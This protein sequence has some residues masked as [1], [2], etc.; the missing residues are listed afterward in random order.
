MFG[1][2]L[3]G[4]RPGRPAA[5]RQALAILLLAAWSLAAIPD[6]SFAQGAATLVDEARKAAREDR[7]EEAA[8]LFERALQA[9]PDLRSS[10]LREYADQLTYSRRPAEAVPL[11]R[12]VLARGSLPAEEIRRAER[13]LALALL[14]SGA[15]SEAVSVWEAINR[16][17]PDDLDARK[18]FR[19]ALISAAREAARADQNARSAEF[20]E[21]AIR[22]D[23]ARRSE[24]L[25]EYADQLTFSGRARD[26]VPLFDEV[27]AAPGLSAAR[28]NEAVRGRA[29]AYLFAGDYDRAAAAW[30]EIAS[31][32]PND[33]DA[34]RNLSSAIF[35]LAREAAK[36]NRNRRSA[37]LYEQLIELD[38]GRRA[39][40]L[41]E[42]ADQL[43]FSGQAA[44]A[45]PLFEEV[46]ASKTLSE[47]DKTAAA[48]G[49]AVA[50]LF[51]GQHQRARTAWETIL[52]ANP[53]DRDAAKNLR[54]A[55]IGLA[56]EAARRDQNARSASLFAEAIALD[57][58]RRRDILQEYA[59]QLTY[60]GQAAKAV[61]LFDEILRDNQLNADARKRA[62]RGRA[63]ALLF[64]EDFTRAMAAWREILKD[65]PRDTD[66]RK[67]LFDATVGAAR[68][69]A[70]S[71]QNSRSAT[72]FEHA[73]ATAPHR[74]LEILREYAD[75][76][77][78][79]E[80]AAQ[81]V[82]LYQE[83]LDQARLDPAGRRQASLGLALAQSWSGDLTGA[84][85]T[86]D[87][88]LREQPQDVEARLGRGRVLSW[89][90][91]HDESLREYEFV[92]ALDPGSREGIR[93]AARE[94]SY[95]GRHRSALA[96]LEPLLSGQLSPA[97]AEALNVAARARYWMGRPDAAAQMANLILQWDPR[98]RDAAALLVEIRRSQQPETAIQASVSEQN[99]GLSIR[100]GSV[101][102]S[103]TLNE[104]LTTLG[105][106]GRLWDFVPRAGPSVTLRALGLAG[107]HRFTDALEINSQV[108][109]NELTSAHVEHVRV[110]HDTWITFWPNDYLRFDLGANRNYFD[111][112]RSL[113]RDIV[114][115]TFGLSVDVTP[116]QNTRL[117]S[118]ASYGLISDGN[119]RL[120]GQLEAERRIWNRPNLFVGAKLTG[121]DFARQVDNG[122]FNPDWLVAA[123][124]MLRLQFTLNGRLDV[125]L[126]GS[127]G[128][129]RSPDGQ[130]PIYSGA[131]QLSYRPTDQLNLSA[132]VSYQESSSVG[133][134]GG[135]RRATV[136]GSL[137]Y[138]W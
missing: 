130:K 40:V 67:N 44:K 14:W 94:E 128:S 15:G 52:R 49:L 51:S 81:A 138:R 58:H 28:R 85:V 98:N 19:E 108:F 27:L 29:L 25:R 91:R 11:Y 96:R 112:V 1:I 95:L 73:L 129:E 30:R 126:R 61:P 74:R 84:F 22:V 54:D 106:Q 109:L 57:P 135:F 18:N 45:V 32:A 41:R 47:G 7:N 79:S 123:E 101:L 75:Q 119:R 36:S 26:A 64:S 104:G 87:A 21:R 6:R 114:M 124:G 46:L 60:S 38:P 111:D 23:P 69:A 113:R 10:L 137:Q 99:D 31:D 65:D 35:G 127:A 9:E 132:E 92:L 93:G 48:R 34:R 107:R 68:L 39:E 88:I 12:E 4:L 90:G 8:R 78:Y 76:L 125:N 59:D 66:A 89:M 72:L 131:L 122:Y 121:F 50:L 71:N 82:P 56:R 2:A 13:G 100:R 134:G 115:D 70:R 116:D 80:R 5:T 43:T 136:G 86:Y 133:G 3:R 105:V 103:F 24:I 83:V 53:R 55:V 16:R 17:V 117:T 97:D 110:T 77:T 62:A 120:F 37:A 63:L 42:Y 102:Q 33:A 20:F 118:R